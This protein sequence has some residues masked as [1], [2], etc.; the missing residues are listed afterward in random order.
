MFVQHKDLRCHFENFY[1][2]HM[3]IKP[4][5][6]WKG[7]WVAI[8]RCILEKRNSVIF[9]L[10]VPNAEEIF[11]MA[12]LLTWLWLKHRVCSFSYAFSNWHLN[13]SQCLQSVL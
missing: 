1:L 9:K 5:Q 4:N 10:G 13:P 3:S 7:M 8:V 2:A 11:Q 6:V 12:Q